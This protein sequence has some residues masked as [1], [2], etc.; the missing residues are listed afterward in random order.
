MK[1][2]CVTVYDIFWTDVIFLCDIFTLLSF[3]C[4]THKDEAYS[5]F[6]GAVQSQFIHD[7]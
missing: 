2:N 1:R 4:Q 7:N 5:L 3:S 6:L